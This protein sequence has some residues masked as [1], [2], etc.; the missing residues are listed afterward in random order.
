MI[1]TRNIEGIYFIGIGGIGMSAL[2]RYFM[3]GGIHVSG[4]DRSKNSITA[5]LSENGCD[6]SFED[7]PGT[8]PDLYRDPL[9]KHRTLVIYT[10]AIPYDNRIISYF[11]NCDYKLYKR[12]EILEEI[13]EKADIIAVSGTHGKTTVSTMIAHLL[14][15][16]HIDCSAFLGGISKNYN[17]NLL[18]GENR[19]TVIEADEYDRSFHRLKPLIAVVTSLDADH[20]DIYGDYKSMIAGYN[21]FCARIRVGGKLIINK[22]TQRDIIIPSGVSCFTY[23]FTDD[24][25][26]GSFNIRQT[27]DTYKFDLKTP[28]TIIQDIHF[29]FPGKINIENATVAIAVALMCGVTEQ[30]IRKAIILFKGVQRRFDIRINYPDLVYIDDYAHHPEEIRACITSVKEYFGGRKITVIFQPHLYS[31]T[32]DHAIGFAEILDKMDE[33]ILLPIYAAREKPIEGVSSEMIFEKMKSTNK[34]LLNKEDIPDKLDIENLDVLLTIGAGD[35]DTLVRPIE[36]KIK[37][38]RGK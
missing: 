29:S 2:A 11:R 22:R 32:R 30:E 7:D 27:G 1:D 14:K 6:I 21:E 38:S 3:A 33:T 17:S 20:L 25:D 36:E 18:L 34:R 8:L 5:D 16:S 31:R 12:S 4:Y 26:Y 13:S 19:Y 10:P 23:G 24:A 35:I 37:L 9:K 15:Q 28:D